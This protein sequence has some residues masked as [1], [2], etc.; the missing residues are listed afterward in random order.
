M[1]ICNFEI[2]SVQLFLCN[3]EQR[4]ILYVGIVLNEIIRNCVF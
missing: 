4:R 3:R 1:K 2:T